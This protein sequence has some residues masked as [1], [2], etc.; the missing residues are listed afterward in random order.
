[1]PKFKAYDYGPFSA[2]VYDDLEFL[3]DIGFVEMREL[4]SATPDPVE[5]QEFAHWQDETGDDCDDVDVDWFESQFSL[6]PIGK[7]FV[8]DDEAGR[9]NEKQWSVIESFKKRCTEADLYSLLRY[10]YTTYPDMAA[11]SRIREKFLYDDDADIRLNIS[12][13]TIAMSGSE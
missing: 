10:V 11:N 1:M 12:S 9:L 13:S 3:T 6:S 8:E 4:S 7:S 2:Q 5:I